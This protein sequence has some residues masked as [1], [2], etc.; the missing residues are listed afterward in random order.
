M[1]WKICYCDHNIKHRSPK[2]LPL[3][4]FGGSPLPLGRGVMCRD[5][6]EVLEHF[7]INYLM[8]LFYLYILFGFSFLLF[9]LFLFLFLFSFPLFYCPPSFSSPK[10][11]IF[12]FSLLFFFVFRLSSFVFSPS[13][14]IIISR[15]KKSILL[16]SIRG[17][18]SSPK[19]CA[20]VGLFFFPHRH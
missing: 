9:F 10:F 13:P 17:G 1:L 4:T 7:F 19:G 3:A 14:L 11:F 2:P 15:Y 20:G 18:A 12:C 16:P 8:F 6:L 5:Y